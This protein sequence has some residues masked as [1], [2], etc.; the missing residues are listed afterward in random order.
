M[1]QYK[2]L[3]AFTLAIVAL[4]LPACN[5]SSSGYVAEDDTLF[6]I[7]TLVSSNSNGSTFSVQK[8]DNSVP[9][10]LS[11]TTA[12]DTAQ[13]GKRI[14]IAYT[15]PTGVSQYTS[16]SVTLVG[17]VKVVNDTVSVAS[18]D[19]FNNESQNVLVANMVGNYLDVKSQCDV[20]SSP[21]TF[22]LVM[23]ADTQNEAYPTV[24]LVFKSDNYISASQKDVYASFN[25]AKLRSNAAYSGF[26][27]VWSPTSLA[28][29]GTRTFEFNNKLTPTPTE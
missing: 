17:A 24:Y 10:T 21:K 27:L 8:D 4:L 26:K 6:D 7:V 15:L 18:A 16:S 19:S 23:D 29:S 3:L 14:L 25:I 13:V 28:A 9:V 1:K 11:C 22:A 2:T 12:I 20:Y 5:S